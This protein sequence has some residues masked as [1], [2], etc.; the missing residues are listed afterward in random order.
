[1]SRTTLGRLAASTDV[2]QANA[3]TKTLI[4]FLVSFG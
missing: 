4:L 2:K 3:E 1:M